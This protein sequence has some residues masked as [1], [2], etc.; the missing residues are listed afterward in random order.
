MYEWIS[1]TQNAVT[2]PFRE[3]CSAIYSKEQSQNLSPGVKLPHPT[4]SQSPRAVVYQSHSSSLWS[5]KKAMMLRAAVRWSA[6]QDQTSRPLKL[7]THP[8]R[9]GLLITDDLLVIATTHLLVRRLTEKSKGVIPFRIQ[10]I[11]TRIVLQKIAS[12]YV[13][14]VRSVRNRKGIWQS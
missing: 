9:H 6:R 5:A 1:Y 8:L 4:A 13:A 12:R 10:V 3:H 2:D 11:Q 7:A 14:D